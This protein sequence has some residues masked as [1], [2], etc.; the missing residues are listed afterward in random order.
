[1]IPWLRTSGLGSAGVSPGVFFLNLENISFKH[2][3]SEAISQYLILKPAGKGRVCDT[4]KR[5][6]KEFRRSLGY[7]EWLCERTENGMNVTYNEAY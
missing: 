2:L 1:M 3:R 5:G 4:S 7:C 6:S